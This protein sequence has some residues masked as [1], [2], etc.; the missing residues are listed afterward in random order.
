M[1]Y[2]FCLYC[3]NKNMQYFVL[4]VVGRNAASERQKGQRE[5][6][7]AAVLAANTIEP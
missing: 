4:G 6:K 1:N 5:K 2:A 3:H 7:E